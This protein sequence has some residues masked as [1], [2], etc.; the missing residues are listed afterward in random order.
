MVAIVLLSINFV[1]KNFSYFSVKLTENTN[2]N[3]NVI[4]MQNISNAMK[5]LLH[6]AYMTLKSVM[7][8][9][10][11]PREKTS[12]YP[13]VQQRILPWLQLSVRRITFTT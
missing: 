9:Q 3:S 5:A 2:W 12:H 11:V 4:I 7:E 6:F 10:I 1:L 13:Y 8:L